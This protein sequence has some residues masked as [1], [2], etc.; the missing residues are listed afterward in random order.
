MVARQL[1]AVDSTA[2]RHAVKDSAGWWGPP[3][4]SLGPWW[5]AWQ[6]PPASVM[7]ARLHSKHRPKRPCR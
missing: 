4:A 1:A 2:G 6:I 7:I 5:V 3:R